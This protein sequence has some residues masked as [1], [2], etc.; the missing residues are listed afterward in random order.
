MIDV[1]EVLRRWQ[2]GQSA[3]AIARDGVADRKTAGRYVEA[4]AACELA[5][6]EELTDAVVRRIAEHVQARPE[7]QRSDP[8]L[9]LDQHRQ[10]IQTWIEQ[11]KPLKLVRVHELLARDGIE[12]SYTTLRRYVRS[13]FG[14]RERTPTVLLDDPPPGEEAQ[15]D[16]GLMGYVRGADGRRRKLWVLIAR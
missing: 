13:E 16:F 6:G 7:P 4:A 12:V 9:L 11:D 3:R 1:R 5:R 15:V 14:W 8:R 10:R 2:A